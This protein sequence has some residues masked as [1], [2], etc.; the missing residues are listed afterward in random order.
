MPSSAEANSDI[1]VALFV[2]VAFCLYLQY[3]KKTMARR[4][5]SPM[6]A[7]MMTWSIPPPGQSLVLLPSPLGAVLAT[8]R[9]VAVGKPACWS[10]SLIAVAVSLAPKTASPAFWLAAFTLMSMRMPAASRR[11]IASWQIA[12]SR[13]ALLMLS[14]LTMVTSALDT[15]AAAAIAVLK[16]ACLFV[17]LFI[18]LFVVVKP[19]NPHFASRRLGSK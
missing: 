2:S 15:P 7:P 14:I 1:A 18:C 4:T 16:V 19:E 12:A 6:A 11:R 3:K 10:W 13:R 8:S 5:V 17:C 9:R